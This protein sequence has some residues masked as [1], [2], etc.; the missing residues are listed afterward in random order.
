M[1]LCHSLRQLNRC[2][3]VM[4]AVLKER[5]LCLSPQKTR[6]G[7][8]EKGFHFL[9]ISYPGTQTQGNNTMAQAMDRAAIPLD[10]A[11][12]STSLRG[13]ANDATINQ[14]PELQR[15]VPHPRTLRKAREQVKQ[16]LPM[17]CLL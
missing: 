13:A 11:H 14:T 1:I 5:R 3:Q 15:I 10:N 12:Y 8:I 17:R 16:M 9:G 6:I 4:M 2:K 7:R